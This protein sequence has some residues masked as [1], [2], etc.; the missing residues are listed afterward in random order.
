MTDLAGLRHVRYVLADNPVTAGAFALFG[1]FLVLALFG[2][3]IAPFDPLAT[4]PD[5]VL[6]PPSSV[7]WFGTDQLGRDILSRVI[8]ATADGYGTTEVMR[9]SGLAKPVV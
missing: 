2:P 8:V 1:L 3:W 9:R 4:S 6:Q 5:K 7:H